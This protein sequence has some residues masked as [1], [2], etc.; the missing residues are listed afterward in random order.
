MPEKFKPSST[1]RDKNT[2]KNKIEHYYMK[3]TPLSE[4]LEYIEKS[5][6]RPKIV[7]KVKRELTRRG[8]K[9]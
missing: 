2:G 5:S 1:V 8:H 6:A 9:C 7:S 3:T 4:L